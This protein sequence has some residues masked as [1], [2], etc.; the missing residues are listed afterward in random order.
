M[1]LYRIEGPWSGR[2]AVCSRP[3][4]GSWLED[5]ILALREAGHDL[6][7]SALTPEEIDRLELTLVP[8][9]CRAHGVRFVHYPVGNLMVPDAAHARPYLEEWHAHLKERGGVALHCWAS[10]GR[11]AM[12]A[13]ALLVLG[14]VPPD[15]AWA[16][17]E[18]ARGRQVPDTT[19]QRLWAGLIAAAR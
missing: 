3:R 2:L 16:R 7:V 8:E 11:S 19:E 14:G 12:L 4:S 9:I 10:V 13:A 5:D 18:A 6:L 1:D 15:E 17:I